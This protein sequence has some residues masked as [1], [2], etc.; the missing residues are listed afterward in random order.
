M[1]N[2]SGQGATRCEDVKGYKER[3]ALSQCDFLA[4]SKA[5]GGAFRPTDALKGALASAKKLVHRV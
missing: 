2:R 3:V 1:K 4:F 5:L